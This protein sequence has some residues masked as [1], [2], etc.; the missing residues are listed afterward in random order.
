MKTNTIASCIANKQNFEF[1][2][3]KHFSFSKDLNDKKKLEIG[4]NIC[5]YLYHDCLLGS[6]QHSLMSIRLKTNFK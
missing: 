4:K 2:L 5:T 1:G 3:S 6:R